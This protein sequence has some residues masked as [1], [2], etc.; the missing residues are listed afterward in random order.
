MKKL[1]ASILLASLIL[2]FG[3]KTSLYI[4]YIVHFTEYQKQCINKDKISLA[5]NGSCAL[6]DKLNAQEKEE[7]P[8][9]PAQLLEELPHFIIPYHPFFIAFNINKSKA[10]DFFQAQ[11]ISSTKHP[12][13]PPPNFV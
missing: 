11:L 1:I 10:F 13:T 7:T 5:C 9:I 3:L 2:P 8:Q 6:A 12:N 4:D